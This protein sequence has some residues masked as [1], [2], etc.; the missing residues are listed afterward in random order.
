MN[1][2]P[3]RVNELVYHNDKPV[4]MT[5]PVGGGSFDVEAVLWRPKAES[6]KRLGLFPSRR[7][8]RA[9]ILKAI[10]DKEKRA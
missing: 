4:G 2:P 10:A 6:D 1:Q 3:Q 5:V 9:A 8:A 7:K